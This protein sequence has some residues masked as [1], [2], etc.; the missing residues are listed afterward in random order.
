MGF[1]YFF[2]LIEELLL[3]RVVLSVLTEPGAGAWSQLQAPVPAFGPTGTFSSTEP[4]VEHRIR[5][6]SPAS[7][8]RSGQIVSG[9]QACPGPSLLKMDIMLLCRFTAIL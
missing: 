6:P 9:V 4:T 7:C 3:E 2:F 1:V 8:H 5:W